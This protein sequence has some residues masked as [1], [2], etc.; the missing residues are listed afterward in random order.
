M[1]DILSLFF[2]KDKS[3]PLFLPL[4]FPL[5]ST[6]FNQQTYR[7]CLSYARHWGGEGVEDTEMKYTVSPTQD[8]PRLHSLSELCSQALKTDPAQSPQKTGLPSASA[9]RE[10]WR[11]WGR[12]IFLPETGAAEVGIGLGM[13]GAGGWQLSCQV[14]ELL[15]QGQHAS[16]LLMTELSL[17][18][19]HG[20]MQ[21]QTLQSLPR[22]GD[23]CHGGLGSS[24]GRVEIPSPRSYHITQSHTEMISHTSVLL[25]GLSPLPSL[26]SPTSGLL[27]LTVSHVSFKTQVPGHLL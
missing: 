21:D 11:F 18:G 24:A 6:V 23:R 1:N 9:S 25:H 13:N 7:K 3:I 19:C 12:R 27:H 8:P 2:S 5:F 10:S 4:S 16:A 22:Q 20:I 15:I 26:S 14:Q 17:T